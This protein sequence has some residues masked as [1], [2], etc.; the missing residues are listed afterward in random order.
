[1][2]R[3]AA[4][5][6]REALEHAGVRYTFGIPGV[7]NTEIYDELARSG[8]ITPVLVTHEGGG[9]FMADAVSRS[10]TSLGT[11]VIVPAAGV[12][13]AASGIAEAFLDGI[14][15]LVISGG[16]RRDTGRQY[17]LHDVNQ[18]ALLKPITKATWLVDRHADVIPTI[19]EAV[20]VATSGEP[21]PVFVEVP[22]NLQMLTGDP[23]PSATPRYQGPAVPEARCTA[24]GVGTAARLLA[25]AQSPTIF[26]GWGAVD[27]TAEVAALAEMLGAPVSTTLQGVSAFPGNHPLHAGFCLGRASVPAVEKTFEHTDCMLAVGTRFSEI[28]TGSYGWEPPANLVHVDVNPAVFDANY[29]AKVCLEGDAKLVLQKLIAALGEA[30]AGAAWRRAAVEATIRAEKAAYLTDWQQHDSQGRV[31][32][33]RFFTSLRRQ[34]ADDATVVLDDGNHTF[35][36]A[37][38][39]PIHRPRGLISPTDFNCMGYCV[40]ATI[41]SKLARREAQVVG[42]VGDGAFRMTGLELATATALGLGV[43]IFVFGDG[44]LAQISQAQQIPYNR[45]TCTVLGPLDVAGVAQA[46]GASFLR[47]ATDAD[48]DTVI[49]SALARAAEG[50]PVLVDV[51]IDYTKR[52]RFTEGIVRTNFERFDLGTKARLVGRALWRRISG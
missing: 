17:Q 13:H 29:P 43:V 23:G 41:G 32:P 37:E 18:H 14:P 5:L 44:E 21:G 7:H 6:L 27:A 26:V 51:A 48:I 11:L 47:L 28:A 33:A 1:V 42:I 20:R 4:S 50:M 49:A 2:S 15:M 30:P 45:K 31:N 9:A 19:H 10:G 25:D 35:L 24:A 12:T 22:V 38:L 8:T 40:P 39:L 36:A 52:T 3:T 46:T 34:L 16:I